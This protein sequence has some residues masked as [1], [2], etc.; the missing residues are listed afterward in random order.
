MSEHAQFRNKSEQVDA[1]IDDVEPIG[2]SQFI[3]VTCGDKP[4]I[5]NKDMSSGYLDKHSVIGEEMKITFNLDHIH[6]FDKSS[7][8]AIYNS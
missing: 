7:Q 5:A 4:F 8:K 2:D 6:I 1:R 3:C